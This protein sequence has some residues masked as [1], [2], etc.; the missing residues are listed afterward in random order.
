M[1]SLEDIMTTEVTTLSKRHSVLDAREL[2]SSQ[3]IRHIPITDAQG[4]LEGIFSQRDL[5]AVMDSTESDLDHHERK[6]RESQ[7]LLKE[8]MT[9]KVSTA[10]TS[11]SLREAAMFLQNKKYG[12]LPIVEE[13]KIKGIVT[14]TDFISVAIN[15]LEQIEDGEPLVEED[16][17]EIEV[18]ELSV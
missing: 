12:C 14:D 10:N 4:K 11:V 5:L 13:G 16:H 2:M 1:I 17:L 8:V 6:T 3:G 9:K 18:V 15:L 7:I